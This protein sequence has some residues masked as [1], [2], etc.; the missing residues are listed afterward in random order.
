MPDTLAESDDDEKKIRKPKKI[1]YDVESSYL[2]NSGMYV[3]FI[4]NNICAN[5]NIIV[6]KL[7]FLDTTSLKKV[8]QKKVTM[9]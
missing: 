5:L 7:T 6:N 9:K 1:K 3:R 4:S 8:L 2:D